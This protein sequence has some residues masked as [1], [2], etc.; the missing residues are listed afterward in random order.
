M[1][2]RVGGTTMAERLQGRRDELGTWLFE[3][4][5]QGELA[6]TSKETRATGGVDK[7]VGQR[8]GGTWCLA[9]KSSIAGGGLW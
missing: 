4:P 8:R 2:G 1:V 5:A 7:D 3:D 9:P 6:P